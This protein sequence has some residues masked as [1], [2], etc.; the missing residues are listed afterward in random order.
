MTWLLI[1]GVVTIVSV[2]ATIAVCKMN[3]KK[4]TSESKLHLH[5]DYLPDEIETSGQTTTSSE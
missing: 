2:I 4:L 5:I 3:K 1:A